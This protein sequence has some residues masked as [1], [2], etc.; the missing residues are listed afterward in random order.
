MPASAPSHSIA[1]PLL[2]RD[3]IRFDFVGYGA[4]AEPARDGTRRLFLDVGNDLRP[5]VIDH[6]H[7]PAYTGSTARLVL[8]HADLVAEHAASGRDAA[9]PF[10][11]VLHVDPDL[12]GVVSSYLAVAL[13]TTGSF[14]PGAE[15]LARYVD[16]VDGGHTGLSQDQPFT[17]YAAYMLL[18]HRLALRSWREPVDRYRACVE[19]G[20]SIVAF[21]AEQLARTG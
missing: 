17:L 14:P 20:L 11:I 18:A 1:V 10:S 2:R 15:A 7:L 3:L 19:E 6:H 5:G 9:A 8:A 16:R 13:L 21:V 12:D 4:Q